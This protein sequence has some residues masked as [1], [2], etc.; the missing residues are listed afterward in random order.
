MTG[1]IERKAKE[2]VLSILDYGNFNRDIAGHAQVMS[3]MNWFA[4]FVLENSGRPGLL[5]DVD[6]P[7]QECTCH[8][9]HPP[10]GYCVNKE[11]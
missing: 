2:T 1:Q 6:E 7:L 9:G 8:L 4:K 11:Q 5:Q 10:C 3:Y